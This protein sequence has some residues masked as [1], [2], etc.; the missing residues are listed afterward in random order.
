MGAAVEGG[1]SARSARTA[2]PRVYARPRPTPRRNR[3]IDDV[4]HR[5]RRRP[6]RTRHPRHPPQPRPR[7]PQPGSHGLDRHPLVDGLTGVPRSPW[8]GAD[9]RRGH[10]DLPGQSGA[11]PVERKRPADAA[12]F[13]EWMTPG[14]PGQ[15]GTSRASRPG[16]AVAD[17]E[18]PGAPRRVA[19][20]QRARLA[21]PDR[22]ERSSG[23]TGNCHRPREPGA[24]NPR[25]RRTP[26]TLRLA[27]KRSV[28][29]PKSAR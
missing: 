3:N 7:R 6:P 18:R 19:T 26:P 16:K 17:P 24:V 11:E 21:S 29:N 28:A 23:V 15:T 2:R 8:K 10:G 1:V 5:P 4:L 13:A 20:E 22:R 27:T 14:L 25:A 12:H 9:T